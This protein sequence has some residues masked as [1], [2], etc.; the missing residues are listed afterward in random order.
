MSQ[1]DIR[2]LAID[3]KG[4]Q[5]AAANVYQTVIDSTAGGRTISAWR[6][7]LKGR[8][9]APP[10]Q[11]DSIWVPVGATMDI[12]LANK[13]VAVEDVRCKQQ[14]HL[15]QRLAELEA[16]KEAAIVRADWS[17]LQAQRE[18]IDEALIQAEEVIKSRAKK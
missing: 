11:R 12:T 1:A 18:M 5:I 16:Q 7:C 8:G 4:S 13:R 6:Q 10:T 15:V 9:I 3:P 2:R 14:T 17:A